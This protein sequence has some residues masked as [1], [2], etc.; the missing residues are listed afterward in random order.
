MSRAI[1]AEWTKFRTVHS[2][3]WLLVALAA[4]TAGLSATITGTVSTNLCPTPS[5]CLEDTTKLSLA[6]IWAGQLVVAVIAVLAVTNEY[7]HRTMSLTLLAVPQRLR[8]YVAKCLVVLGPVVVASVVGVAGSLL[9]ARQILPANGFTEANGYDALS[10]GDDPTLRAAVGT[11]LYLV[12][13]ALLSLGVGTLIRDTAVSL[14]AVLAVLFVVPMLAE[15]VSDPQWYEWVQ[16]LSPASAGQAIQVT[17]GIDEM[18][19]APWPGLGILALWAVG[20]AAAGAATLFR[21]DA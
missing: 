13:I 9:A 4:L 20:A 17:M 16:R 5:Q 2:S 3:A 6:G 1:W 14:T 8:A 21:R 15:F 11:V 12:L 7:T 18:P 10:I 19:I